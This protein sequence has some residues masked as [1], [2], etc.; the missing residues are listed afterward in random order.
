ML[1]NVVVEVLQDRNAVAAKTLLAAK[2]IEAKSESNS[3]II[4]FYSGTS[5]S[6]FI[7]FQRSFF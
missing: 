5:R 2:Q 1:I 4:E 3:I 6:R 7:R